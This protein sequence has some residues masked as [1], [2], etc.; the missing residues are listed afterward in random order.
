MLVDAE[1]FMHLII[2]GCLKNSNDLLI[3]QNTVLGWILSGAIRT[4]NIE[5][6]G[7][8]TQSAL[9]IRHDSDLNSQMEKFWNI[10]EVTTNKTLTKEEQYCEE[11]FKIHTR[12]NDKGRFVVRLPQKEKHLKLG[13][14]YNIALKRF[15]VL[16]QKLSANPELKTDYVNFMREYEAL[17]HMQ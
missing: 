16:E 11:Q 1:L 8:T 4:S 5:D 2:N 6:N 9:F 10:E 14:S 15:K 12:R 3:L 17:D 7:K 13:T